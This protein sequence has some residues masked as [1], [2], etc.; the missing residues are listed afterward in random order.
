M[1]RIRLWVLIIGS[2]ALLVWPQA[3]LAGG[4]GGGGQCPGFAAGAT[5][6]MQDNCFDGIAHFAEVET[7]LTVRNAGILPHSYTAVDGSF[8]TGILGPGET[9]EVRLGAEGI[10]R[11]FCTLHGTAEG[12]GMAGVLLV[13][14]PKPEGLGGLGLAEALDHNLRKREEL[15]MEE[16]SA[17]SRSLA[18]LKGEIAAVKQLVQYAVSGLGITVV[19][20]L[21]GALA[22]VHRRARPGEAPEDRNASA[23]VTNPTG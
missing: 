5:L 17:Q 7:T 22:M 23:R 19:A 10:V 21:G 1:G 14:S 16:I 13:G 4:G 12:H 9:A 18:E 20:F 6:V 11:A 3:G 15:V 2:S 8:D